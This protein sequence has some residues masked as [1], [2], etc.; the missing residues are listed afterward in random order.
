[1]RLTIKNVIKYY[2]SYK[3]FSFNRLHINFRKINKPMLTQSVIKYDVL[4]MYHIIAIL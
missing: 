1:M 4:Q 3:R 2:K